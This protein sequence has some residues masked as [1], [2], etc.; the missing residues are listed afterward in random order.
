MGRNDAGDKAVQGRAVVAGSSLCCSMR[1]KVESI[2]IGSL[3]KVIPLH[4]TPL[5]S[6]PSSSNG[7]KYHNP[8]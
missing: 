4:T 1:A 7:P 8:H 2:R 6:A 3:A 5:S